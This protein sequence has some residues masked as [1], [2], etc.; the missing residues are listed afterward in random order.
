VIARKK[1]VGSVVG[2]PDP[3]FKRELAVEADE[4]GNQHILVKAVKP[5]RVSGRRHG[6]CRANQFGSEQADYKQI[7]QSFYRKREDSSRS[8]FDLNSFTSPPDKIKVSL[9]FAS[10]QLADGVS[11]RDTDLL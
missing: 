9:G 4:T 2:Q 6:T 1:R 7:A 5:Q 10:E 3:G 11:E 8:C